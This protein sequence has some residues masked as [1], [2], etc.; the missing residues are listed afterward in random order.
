[1]AVVKGLMHDRLLCSDSCIFTSMLQCPNPTDFRGRPPAGA[2]RLLAAA[3]AGLGYTVGWS[4][5]FPFF[6]KFDFK[7]LLSLIKIKTYKFACS[8]IPGVHN[9]AI[10]FR[11][12][13]SEKQVRS[14]LR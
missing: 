1:M 5:R 9:Y 7:F 6:Y 11:E 12:R 13:K 3:L 4:I 10:H 8:Q 2:G 14:V